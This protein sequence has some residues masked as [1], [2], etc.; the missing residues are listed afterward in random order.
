VSDHY[1]PHYKMWWICFQ[2]NS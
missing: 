1:T 2:W